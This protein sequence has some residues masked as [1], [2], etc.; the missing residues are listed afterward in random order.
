M[1][2]PD[3]RMIKADP[4]NKALGELRFARSQVDCAK[5]ASFEGR[6][7]SALNAIDDAMRRLE[8]AMEE[9]RRLAEARAFEERVAAIHEGTEDGRVTE[10]DVM[11]AGL[12]VG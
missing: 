11:A 6:R 1:Y 9:G 7:E 3:L 12:A 10:A 8:E 5:P 2:D 4:I